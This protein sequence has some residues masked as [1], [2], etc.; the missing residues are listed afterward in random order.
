MYL[1]GADH[2]IKSRVIELVPQL[3]AARERFITSAETFQEV[4]HRYRAKADW[5]HLSAA[6]EA[7]EAMVSLTA[8]V[9]KE[10]VD[11]ARML[12]GGYRG[13]SARD[14]LHVAVMG[15]VGCNVIWSYDRGL[16][17]VTSIQRI[18]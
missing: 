7:L 5:E 1:V 17:A 6:Y 11:A 12:S 13:L 4:L 15:R 3:V 16:S 10:D 14:C 9:T 18:E 8:D 2:P